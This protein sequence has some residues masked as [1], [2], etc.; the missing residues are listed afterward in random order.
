MPH[1]SVLPLFSPLLSSLPQAHFSTSAPLSC[2]MPDGSHRDGGPGKRMT[3][4]PPLVFDLEADPVTNPLS[5][6]T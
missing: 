3:H 1:A 5:L 2:R 6:L 4:D